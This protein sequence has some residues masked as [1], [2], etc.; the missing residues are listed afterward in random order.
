MQ[1]PDGENHALARVQIYVLHPFFAS[2]TCSVLASVQ[3][4]PANFG[5]LS[6]LLVLDLGFCKGLVVSTVPVH[7]QDLKSVF[8]VLSIFGFLRGL[9]VHWVPFSV[10]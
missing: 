10:A 6:S 3:E 4:L 9:W 2:K 1:E 7:W 5:Q 8:F